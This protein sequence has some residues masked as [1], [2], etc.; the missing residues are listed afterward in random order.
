MRSLY[1]FDSV[2]RVSFAPPYKSYV[3]LTWVSCDQAKISSGENLFYKVTDYYAGDMGTGQLV[4]SSTSK[5]GDENDAF[6]WKRDYN[7]TFTK[8]FCG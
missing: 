6:N 2:Q 3:E 1:S 7:D 4:K 5:D 8:K